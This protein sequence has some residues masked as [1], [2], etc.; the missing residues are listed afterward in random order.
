MKGK[1]LNPTNDVTFK[2]VFGEASNNADEVSSPRFLFVYNQTNH[3][4][5]RIINQLS[6]YSK[7]DYI[8]DFR[9]LT[10]WLT[11]IDG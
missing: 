4:T 7:L 3:P 5:H 9:R 10:T 8:I 2:K 1:Y 11:E 6:K